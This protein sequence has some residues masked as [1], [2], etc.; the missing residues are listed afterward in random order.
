MVQA[1]ELDSYR[2]VK[3]SAGWCDRSAIGV[4]RAKGTDR[5]NLLQRLSTNNVADLKAGEGQQT[6]LVSEKARIIDV[7]TLLVR[8]DDV[9]ILCSPGKQAEIRRWIAKYTIMDDFKAADVSADYAALQFSGP[10]SADI[11]RELSGA[12]LSGLPVSGWLSTELFSVAADIVRLPTMCELSYMALIPAG[13]RESMMQDLEQLA[14]VMPRFSEDVYEV[15][16]IEAGLGTP[17]REWSD[18]H[19]PLEASLV[20]LVDFS[21]GCYIGQEVIARLDT[22]NKVK[23]HLVGFLGNEAIPPG[24]E[25]HDAERLI[26]S[27][28]SSTYSPELERHIALGYIRTQYANPGGSAVATYDGKEYPLEI[29]KLPFTM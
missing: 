8:D 9:L 15:L 13:A 2:A 28:T 14:S 20:G 7:L 5:L 27:I 6:V 4:M 12:E 24:A 11:L 25:F 17:G 21:K 22:Y 10:N 3:R 23:Q 16:R 29:V 26:G 19:N 1:G 18:K